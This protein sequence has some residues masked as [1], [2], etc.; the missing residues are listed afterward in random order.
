MT[1]LLEVEN[2]TCGYGD[3]MVIRDVSLRVA[4]HSITAVLGRNGAGKTT[5]LRGIAG[6]SKPQRG[7][8]YIGGQDVTQE[9]AHTRRSRGVGFVQENKRTFKRRTVEQNLL[10]GLYGLRLGRAEEKVRL[11][12]AYARFPILADRRSQ[13]AGL[14]SGGQQQMLGISQALVSRPDLLLLDEPSMGLAPSIVNEVMSVVRSLRDTEGLGVLLI[15]QAV[16][17]SLA[18]ADEVLL[19]DV[20]RAVHSG[21]A[22]DPNLGQM[23]AATYLSREPGPGGPSPTSSK[24]KLIENGKARHE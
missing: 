1:N 8:V 9:P 13:P 16:E 21:P 4:P 18:L 3:M 19:L 20:G 7:R 11:D 15:E 22:D 17:N 10:L 5:L 6:L 23:V 2:L 14:L 12:E 24:K